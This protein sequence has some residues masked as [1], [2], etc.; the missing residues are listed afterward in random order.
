MNHVSQW[1]EVPGIDDE[2]E[3]SKGMDVE[4]GGRR[5]LTRPMRR[6]RPLEEEY[7][8]EGFDEDDRNEFEERQ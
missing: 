3:E 8:H 4:A 7:E 2:Y 1:G 5:P 6:R